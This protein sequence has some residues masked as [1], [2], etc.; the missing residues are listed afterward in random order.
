MKS[1]RFLITILRALLALLGFAP[2]PREAVAPVPARRPAFGPAAPANAPRTQ[3]PLRIPPT[4]VR[5]PALE[6]VASAGPH[7][8]TRLLAMLAG[9][10]RA[11]GS[12]LP[13]A[14]PAP[15]AEPAPPAPVRARARLRARLRL[16]RPHLGAAVTRRTRDLMADWLACDA[17]PPARGASC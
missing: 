15:Q 4:L 5:P 16:P 14:P 12:R 10:P 3:D 8:W 11:F 13:R 1:P 2:I 9:W 17:P 6:T 7:A